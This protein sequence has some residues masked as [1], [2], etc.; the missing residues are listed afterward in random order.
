MRLNSKVAKELRG[1]A[2][3]RNGTATPS[4]PEFP[5]VARLYSMPVYTT[6]TRT[7]SSY[8]VKEGEMTRV[9]R[10]RTKVQFYSARHR[11]PEPRLLMVQ[12]TQPASIKVDGADVPNPKAGQTFWEPKLEL[13]PVTKPIQ[14][15]AEKKVYRALK[16][17]HK[18]GL[19]AVGG[20]LELLANVVN[21][22]PEAA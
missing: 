14:A 17:M 3:Y 22:Q 21:N 20:A 6:H 8:E 15:A 10:R 1:A 19:L 16:R 2:K 11:R 5:G 18:R 12:H 4:K 9:Y 7:F 13:V